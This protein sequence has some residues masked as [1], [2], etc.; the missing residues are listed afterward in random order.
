MPAIILAAGRGSRLGN[1]TAEL[2]KALL[3]VAGRTLVERQITLLRHCGVGRI[4]VVT[5]FARELFRPLFDDVVQEIHNPRWMTTNNLVTLAAAGEALDGG[6]LLF[7]SDVLLHPGILEAL[8][9]SPHP[10]ALAVDDQRLLADEEMK[11][12]LD[13]AGR[14]TA[15]AK[16]LDPATACGE[17]IGVAKFDSAGAASLRAAMARMITVGQTNEWYE[18]AFQAIAPEVALQTC[19]TAGLP[20][21]EIDTPEDLAQAEA[22]AQT[23]SL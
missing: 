16:T 18:A 5:G 15:I 4:F 13:P 6:F 23:H 12:A 19:S 11:V 1:L 9:V 20:W 17:Y 21:I 22:L 14:M 3:Q 10:C 7:N 8:M 2:P